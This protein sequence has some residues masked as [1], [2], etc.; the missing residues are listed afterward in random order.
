[1]YRKIFLILLTIILVGIIIISCSDNNI[2]TD[3]VVTEDTSGTIAVTAPNGGESWQKGSSQSITWTDN[4]SEN[5][6]IELYKGGAFNATITTSTG[7]SGSYTW[8]IP[9]IFTAAADYKIKI[10]SIADSTIYDYSNANFAITNIPTPPAVPTLLSPANGTVITDLQPT[11]DWNDVSGATSYR[12]MVDNNSDFSSPEIDQTVSES[13]YT[14]ATNF[15]AGTYFWK[16]LSTNSN[17]SSSYSTAWAFTISTSQSI[18]SNSPATVS[19]VIDTTFEVT[20][21]V[22]NCTD[23]F[24]ISF[25][26]LYD[27]NYL[28]VTDVAEEAFLGE[29]TVFYEEHEATNG[30]VS[31]GISRK[32]GQTSVSGSGNLLT[33]TF[34]VMSSPSSDTDVLFDFSSITANDESGNPISFEKIVSTTVITEN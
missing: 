15:S 25:N 2:L 20:I 4:L 17:G 7:S 27:E 23:L 6:K 5:V 24:G 10:T 8:L 3:P 11:F 16:V 26:F 31:V 14:T 30:I 32:Q 18:K 29:D 28:S 21:S 9:T 12:I 19:G 33:I 34:K 22:E 1:M 13:T